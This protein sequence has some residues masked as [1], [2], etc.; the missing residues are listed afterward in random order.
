V[1]IAKSLF[2]LAIVLMG[3]R[4][5]SQQQGGASAS[6]GDG[7]AVAGLRVGAFP[8]E[9]SRA[10]TA[11]TGVPSNDIRAVAV[12]ASGEVYAGTARGLARY[13]AGE[14]ST[15]AAAGEAVDQVAASGDDVWFTSVGRLVHLHG[16]SFSLPPVKVSQIAAG[17]ELFLATEGGLYHL[18][19]KRLVLDAGLARLSGSQPAVRQVAVAMDGRIAVAALN[20]LFLKSAG[21]NW[22]AV[23]PR[24]ATRS[25]AP[26]DVRGV[27]FDSKDHLWF[28]SAQG[29]GCEASAWQLY[30]GADGLPYNDFTTMAAG[31]N[32]TVWFGT[33][34]GAIRYDGKNWEYRQGRRWLPYDDVRSIAVNANGDGWFATAAGVGVI[35]RRSETL[36]AKAKFFEDEIDKRHR[37]TPY[38][39]ISFAYLKNPGDTREWTLSD[40]D[41]DGLWTSMYGAGECFA[42][43][44]TRDPL[45][46]KRAKAAFEALRFLRLVTQGGQHPAPPG[47]IARAIRPTSGPDPNISDSPVHDARVRSTNDALWKV[48]AP[49]WPV[50][51]DGKWYWKSDVS[52]DEL[53]G[54]FFFY[55]LYYD[56]VADSE[57][58][59]SRVRE[60][61]AA[62]A[63]HLLDHNFQMVDHDG[64]PTR[65]GI[66]NPEHLND[67]FNWYED[68]GI[69]SLSILTYMKVAAHITGDP[70]FAAA[71][72]NL[73][74]QHAYAA[75]IL[76]PKSD[77]GPGSGNESDDEMIYM[78][79]Y[80]LIRYE[81]DPALR[82]TY[83][84]AL[85]KQWQWQQQELN[86]LF[87]F[88][89]AAS[90]TGQAAEDSFG[91]VN[92]SP[93]NRGWLEESVDSLERLPLDRI[94]WRLTNSHR[95]DLIPLPGYVQLDRDSAV[96]AGYR[97]NGDVLPIDERW[98]GYWN[99][100]PWELDEGGNGSTLADGEAFL[101]PY[102][103]GLYHKYIRE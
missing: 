62:V 86:P 43:A 36:E 21:G 13:S 4:S 50:S 98:V 77:T 85:Y 19:G 66:F 55:A 38:G 10:Y 12:T 100:D 6:P 46:R 1:S 68:R 93:R 82:Q 92:L 75:N 69:N 24:N 97:V 95:I 101:L 39:Y 27:V 90:C 73:I 102:Y 11:Q 49:R 3:H 34:M 78:N 17:K 59:R 5:I 9:V 70:R 8:E 22:R 67:S 15:V 103:M 29:A 16:A 47:F 42:Y 18:S 41:N 48:I 58:E 53:D 45:A 96:P 76:I 79:Y 35:E 7:T 28:A 65:W 91:K 44:A 64:K 81:T 2:I 74:Q 94:D 51:A 32:G 83:A 30:T 33:R 89:Y 52:S 20:G 25:W 56:L 88:I 57:E 71:A 54:H 23:Y 40:T 87:D 14:W 80:N 84:L 60:Q 37:R 61:V 26:Y 72:R 63:G 31:E 99:T